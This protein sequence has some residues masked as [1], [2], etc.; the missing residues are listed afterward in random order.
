M[1]HKALILVLL[2]IVF[3]VLMLVGLYACAIEHAQDREK[4][5]SE[6]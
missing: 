6:E 1:D 3:C 4:H 5:R 2:G